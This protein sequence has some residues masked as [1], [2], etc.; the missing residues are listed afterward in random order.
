MLRKPHSQKWLC[1]LELCYLKMIAKG[2]EVHQD[3]KAPGAAAH[4]F[5][6]ERP[7]GVVRDEYGFQAAFERGID[8]AA[9]AVADHPSVLFH[10][11]VPVYKSA[12]GGRVFFRDDFHGG[13]KKF[14]KRTLP[15]LLSPALL[16][17]AW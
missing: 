2:A 4:F 14:L 10:N 6:F 8:I 13:K 3:Q 11:V 17:A 9:R 7:G 1:Y 16:L 12:V 5:V 15:F